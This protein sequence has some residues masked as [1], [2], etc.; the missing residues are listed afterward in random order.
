LRKA[1][2]LLKRIGGKAKP[3][4]SV[5]ALTRRSVISPTRESDV[6][7]VMVGGPDLRQTLDLA[8]LPKKDGKMELSILDAATGEPQVTWPGPRGAVSRQCHTCSL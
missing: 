6:V 5:E 4:I 1:P 8:N 3:P 2:E 7:V